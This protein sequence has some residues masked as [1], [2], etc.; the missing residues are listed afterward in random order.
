MA[1]VIAKHYDYGYNIGDDQWECRC[2]HPLNAE[3]VERDHET[4]V[5]AV[6]AAAGYG[7]LEDA[8]SCCCGTCGL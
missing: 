2:D 5:A 8:E 7:K 4:H 1:E 3:S 6:L